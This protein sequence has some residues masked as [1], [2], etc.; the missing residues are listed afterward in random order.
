MHRQSD[1]SLYLL[2]K[3][4]YLWIDLRTRK[5]SWIW[6]KWLRVCHSY[7]WWCVS[8]PNVYLKIWLQL[9]IAIDFDMILVSWMAIPLSFRDSFFIL[10]KSKLIPKSESAWNSNLNYN[11]PISSNFKLL[12]SVQHVNKRFKTLFWPNLWLF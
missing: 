4:Q 12:D 1:V 7:N 3:Q 5:L 10:T 6:N 11:S 8:K 2:D 9:K